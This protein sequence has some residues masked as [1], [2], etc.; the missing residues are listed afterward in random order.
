MGS[1]EEG[2]FSLSL[3][4]VREE[5]FV[6]TR[7]SQEGAL[8]SRQETEEAERLLVRK[9]HKHWHGCPEL[10][11]LGD[12]LTQLVKQLKVSMSRST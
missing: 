11:Y 9:A 5:H 2:T 7:R 1:S 4:S 3:Q 6:F 8:G 12:Q 10:K